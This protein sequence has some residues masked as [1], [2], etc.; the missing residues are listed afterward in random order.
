MFA[1]R[2]HVLPLDADQHPLISDAIANQFASH[3]DEHK[4]CVR[5]LAAPI[6]VLAIVVC[7]LS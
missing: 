6:I 5:I 3:V 4:Q 7:S 2:L 1:P